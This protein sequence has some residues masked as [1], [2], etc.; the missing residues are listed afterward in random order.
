MPTIPDQAMK[1]AWVLTE[2]WPWFTAHLTWP[3]TIYDVTLFPVKQ[4]ET[5]TIDS[6]DSRVLICHRINR[7]K[8]H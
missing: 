4:S 7:V 2:V 1:E 3:I 8:L 6:R 5:V